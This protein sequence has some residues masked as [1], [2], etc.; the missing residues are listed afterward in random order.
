MRTIK[1]HEWVTPNRMRFE[2]LHKTFNR[3]VS[4]IGTGNQIGNTILSSY[5]RP[6]DRTEC[7]GRH[8]LPGH[9][10][11]YDLGWIVKEAPEIAKDWVRQHGKTQS[12]ILY[13]FFHWRNGNRIIHGAIITDGEHN[14]AETFYLGGTV[15]SISVI[16]EAR[17]YVCN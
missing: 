13:L 17:K 11:E 10:Q 15:K 1:K 14:H 8:N 4:M 3:Q 7:N 16:D 6:Y 9:L 2:S 12:F 5:I